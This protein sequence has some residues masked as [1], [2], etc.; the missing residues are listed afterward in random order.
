MN[1]RRINEPTYSADAT[2]PKLPVPPLEATAKHLLDSIRAVCRNREEEAE[3]TA[4]INEMPTNA[5]LQHLQKKL[6]DRR[7]STENWLKEWWEVL[8]YLKPRY[9]VYI[10]TNIFCVFDSDFTKEGVPAPITADA[11]VRA[12]ICVM[13]MEQ[14]R[15]QL[16]AETY[17]AECI[18]K[19]RL[20]MD[21]YSHYFATRI[22]EPGCDRLVI[23]APNKA[24]YVTIMVD[25]G[26]MYVIDLEKRGR[27]GLA[28]D[29]LVR[30]IR[31]CVAHARGVMIPQK[32][33]LVASLTTADRDLWAKARHRLMETDA[34][35]KR[36]FDL[37]D[38]SAC[39]VS[40]DSKEVRSL[41]EAIHMA[42]FGNFTNRF[43]D[44]SF[45][46]LVSANG[47]A[48]TNADHTPMD[49]VVAAGLP[50]D[51]FAKYGRR[52]FE[53][54]PNG[55][56]VD[57]TASQSLMDELVTPLDFVV[58]DDV[59]GLIVSTV[60]P[61]A[62][63]LAKPNQVVISQF[64]EFGKDALQ[65][66][67]VPVDAFIQA[68]LQLAYYRD[69]RGVFAPVYETAMTRSFRYGR[70]E[71]IRALTSEMVEFVT[72]YA[73][74]QSN[75]ESVWKL[76]E[77]A[78]RQH[79]LVTAR[80]VKGQGIDRHLLGLRYLATVEG[81]TD[82]LPGIFRHPALSRSSTW[83]LS[84]SQMTGQYLVGGFCHN[85]PTGYGACYFVRGGE[86]MTTLSC[87]VSEGRTDVHRFRDAFHAAL[88]DLFNL[89]SKHSTSKL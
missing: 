64:R 32:K 69:Q 81:K 86:I 87:N 60:I 15:Q 66:C 65:K 55:G 51:D 12:A 72:A 70:T 27:G 47:V 42:S 38:Q 88:K 5:V 79:Q 59:A 9:P 84:T 73:K 46:Y 20:S 61:A 22:P 29:D 14:H 89:V 62:R 33:P 52:F 78:M 85:V 45:T 28:F 19:V 10:N 39:V 21:Q 83:H 24:R 49:A 13:E 67:R 37:I 58:P 2:L 4:L 1:I 48:M 23:T 82:D 31:G 35:N 25:P 17:P 80:A 75:D 36:F 77:R 34:R 18:G 50:G 30:V 53:Q 57:G 26:Y 7:E 71:T 8:G 11:T 44:K 3:V 54:L 76:F 6:I 16:I 41:D 40:I 43:H 56:R 74:T 68:A 63:E